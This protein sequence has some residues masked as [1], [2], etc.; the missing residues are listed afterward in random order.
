M[1][2]TGDMTTAVANI[3][4]KRMN[5]AGGYMETAADRAAQANAELE[6]SY[7]ELGKAMQETFGFTGWSDMATGIKTELVGALTFTIETIN[8]AKGAWNSFMQLLGV[9]DKPEKPAPEP[10]SYPNGTYFE[11][12]DADGNLVNA[13]RWLNGKRVVNTTGVT[14]TGS[15]K[16][17]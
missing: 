8:E 7:L 13:G 17:G 2:D 6:N 11:T 4:Q 3:I 16:S 1:K 15:D 9:Q 5:D 14:V 12:T 10:S